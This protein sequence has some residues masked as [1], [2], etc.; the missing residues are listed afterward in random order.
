M[1]TKQVWNLIVDAWEWRETNSCPFFSILDLNDLQIYIYAFDTCRKW[2]KQPKS[3][4]IDLAAEEQTPWHAD[5]T[6]SLDMK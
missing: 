1:T 4:F 3:I 2:V 5:A 6:Q